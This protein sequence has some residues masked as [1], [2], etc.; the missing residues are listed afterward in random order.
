MAVGRLALGKVG[1]VYDALHVG[2]RAVSVDGA[3]TVVMAMAA[4][5]ER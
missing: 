3:T 1:M 5:M 2:V 4:D